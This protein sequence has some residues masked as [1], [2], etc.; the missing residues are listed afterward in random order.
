M[1]LKINKEGYQFKAEINKF[2]DLSEVEKSS[3]TGVN[4]SDY[5]VFA[6]RSEHDEV[7]WAKRAAQLPAEK[8]WI[9]EGKTLAPM[10]QGS[11][12]SC[13]AMATIGAVESR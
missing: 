7:H 13:W 6:E 9:R 12:A 11:C 2:T 4:V 8:D 3:N 1:I 5:L 10:E